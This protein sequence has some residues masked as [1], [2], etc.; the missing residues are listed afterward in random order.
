MALA[1]PFNFQQWI[2]EHRHLLKPPVG[3]QQVFT[4]NK[5][6]IVMVV[7]GPNARKDYHYDE[8]EEL[9]L[10][11]EGDIVI[12]VIEDGKPVDIPV[13][14]G[15][16]FLLPGGVPHSPRRPAGTV[17]LVLERYRTAGEL[18]GFLW[19]CENCGT[20]LHEEYAEITDIVQ[21]LPSIMNRFWESEE[22]RTCRS[23]GTVMEKPAPVPA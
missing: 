12:K 8:G 21:Q 10:Q 19:F 17:G 6:F 15:E 14:A 4:D 9:F 2:D 1:R 18:D 20:K 16:M 11:I 5:D 3:N 7:G 22:L 23:C 13:R